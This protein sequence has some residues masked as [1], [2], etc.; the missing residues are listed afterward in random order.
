MLLILHFIVEVCGFYALGFVSLVG[1]LVLGFATH[2][3]VCF[4]LLF[5]YV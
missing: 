5:V 2:V 3:P 1:M 4:T